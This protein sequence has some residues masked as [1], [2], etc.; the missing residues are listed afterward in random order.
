MP[1]ATGLLNTFGCN[2]D[3][4]REKL[5]EVYIAGRPW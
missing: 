4:T 5:E 2:T 1:R 3:N